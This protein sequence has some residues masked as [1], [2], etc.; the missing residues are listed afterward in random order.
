[1]PKP[2][3]RE[4]RIMLRSKRTYRTP[5]RSMGQHKTPIV[6]MVSINDRPAKALDRRVP[7][8]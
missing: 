7:D 6:G 5:R 8:H 4:H 1:M 3:L 2:T